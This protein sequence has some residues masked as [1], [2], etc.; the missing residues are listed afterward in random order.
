[1][2]FKLKALTDIWT[3]GVNSRDGSTLHIT[4]IKG[5]IRWWYEVLIRGLKGYACD[6]S[7]EKWRCTL[8]LNKFKKHYPEWKQ[9]ST[10][11]NL[12]KEY[13]DSLVVKQ[14]SI[15]E[16]TKLIKLFDPKSALEAKLP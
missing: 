5:S 2:E 10:I 15:S 9:K 7:D 11:D 8:D 12:L 1:M 14:E 6:P 16:F 3:G 13:N 4:G